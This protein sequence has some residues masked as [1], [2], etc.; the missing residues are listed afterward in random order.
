MY[1]AGFTIQVAGI[2]RAKDLCQDILDVL[3][4][5]AVEKHVKDEIQRQGIEDENAIP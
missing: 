3:P 2:F 5:Q 1:E 4:E